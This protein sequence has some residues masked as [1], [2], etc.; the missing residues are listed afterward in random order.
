MATFT[1]RVTRHVNS[2]TITKMCTATTITQ[3]VV[4]TRCT[5]A[6]YELSTSGEVGVP[7]SASE[8]CRWWGSGTLSVVHRRS[9]AE[10]DASWVWLVV[11]HQR[12]R[13][14]WSDCVQRDSPVGA[15]PL[16]LLLHAYGQ[17]IS[18][19]GYE[20]WLAE[21]VRR[22]EDDV[23]WFGWVEPSHFRKTT[24]EGKPSTVELV[25]LDYCNAILTCLP[26]LP[27]STLVPL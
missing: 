19:T 3:I 26:G 7:W 17:Y 21:I 24:C 5:S 15:F 1:T 18:T 11:N 8:L 23:N 14:S 10:G 25:C 27:A 13:R 20:P 4:I 2:T 12:R 22:A 6:S 16:Y 9:G